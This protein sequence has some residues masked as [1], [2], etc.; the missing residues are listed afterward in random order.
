[1]GQSRTLS[2]ATP[3]PGAAA[4]VRVGLPRLV[5]GLA[6]TAAAAGPAA[7]LGLHCTA[8]CLEAAG[9]LTEGFLITVRPMAA[10]PAEIDGVRNDLRSPCGRRQALADLNNEH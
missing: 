2:S 7:G 5:L 4:A 8:A 1:M 6:R 9:F 10:L 3:A